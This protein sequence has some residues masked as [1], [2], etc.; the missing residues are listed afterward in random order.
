MKR[1]YDRI[2]PGCPKDDGGV[3]VMPEKHHVSY[4]APVVKS[5]VPAPPNA[6]G[7]LDPQ[8][9]SLEG[10]AVELQFEI[11]QKLPDLPT[12]DAIVH[13]S[14]S[15]HRAYVARRQSILARVI[16]RD[17]GPDIQFEAHAVAMTQTINKENHSEIRAFLKDYRR[18]RRQTASFWFESVPL[19]HVTILSQL[20][21]AVRFA[22]KDFCKT[23]LSRDPLSGEKE[24]DIKP[25][26]TNEA[27]RISRALYRFEL[28]CRI[29]SHA[30]FTVKIKLDCMEMCHLFLNQ[31]PPWEVEEIACIR[32]YIIDRYA[33]LFAK[34]E[35]ELMQH[36]PEGALEGVMLEKYEERCMSH[37]LGFLRSINQASAFDQVCMLKMNLINPRFFLTQTLEEEPYDYV[38][39]TNAFGDWINKLALRFVGESDGPNAAWTWSNGEL[40][41]L[42]AFQPSKENLRKWGYV[43]WDK[44]RL[45]QWGVLESSN[46]EYV[47][48]CYN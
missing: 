43:M 3:P 45:D 8:R 10:L 21:H 14:P 36:L 12:L 5:G 16:S 20:Q 44:E 18:T 42:F 24:K 1:F 26:S 31:F 15:Y 29:F 46:V 25:L 7:G 17:I 9:A 47:R 41:E 32:D 23:T 11:L 4:P 2:R 19:P 34:H 27:R 40:V 38:Y 37:G 39:G 30:G 35:R 48:Q 22:M 33:G 6:R 28:F 13:A